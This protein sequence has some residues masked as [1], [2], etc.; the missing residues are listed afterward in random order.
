MLVTHSMSFTQKYLFVSSKDT[1]LAKDNLLQL[2]SQDIFFFSYITSKALT[3]CP[4]LL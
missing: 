3:F 2:E 4:S 1:K